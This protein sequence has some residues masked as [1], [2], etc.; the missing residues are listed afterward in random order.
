MSI[1]EYYT[2]MKVKHLDGDDCPV[3]GTIEGEDDA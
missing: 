3:C 1:D 2:N